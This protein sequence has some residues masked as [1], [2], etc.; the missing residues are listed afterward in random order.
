[1]SARPG[2]DSQASRPRPGPQR[3]LQ[4]VSQLSG[5]QLSVTKDGA[6]QAGTDYLAGVDGNSGRPAVDVF[7]ED[8]SAA[9]ALSNEARP[10]QGANEFF[11]L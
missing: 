4:Q 11:Y 10:F 5:G 9:R 8:V 3:S 7:L 6:Q 2:F 1:M